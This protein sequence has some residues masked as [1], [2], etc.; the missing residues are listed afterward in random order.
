MSTE[1][2]AQRRAGVGIPVSGAKAAEGSEAAHSLYTMWHSVLYGRL[3]NF[4]VNNR[5][6][7]SVDRDSSGICKVDHHN[8]K[9]TKRLKRLLQAYGIQKP[10]KV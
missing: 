5:V 6:C 10:I 8:S 2:C 4:A 7:H 9:V 3:L 1:P